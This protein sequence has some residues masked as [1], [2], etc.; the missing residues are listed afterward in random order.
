MR[1]PRVA[2]D[3]QRRPVHG[4]DQAVTEQARLQGERGERQVES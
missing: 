3:R 2:V 1:R 4:G